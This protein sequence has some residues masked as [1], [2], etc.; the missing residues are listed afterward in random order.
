MSKAKIERADEIPL[1]LYWL[2]KMQVA[3]VIDRVLPA[4]HGNRQGLS[5]GQLAVLFVVYV[6]YQRSHRLSGMEEWVVAHQGVL[7]HCTGWSIEGQE[8]TDDRLGDLLSELGEE[9]SRAEE[10]QSELGR[11]LLQAYA[12]PT[13]RV[14]YDTTSFSVHHAPQAGGKA[15]DGLLRFGHSK[16][17]RP[18]LLQFKQ[19]LG[20]LD[21]AGVP[22]YTETLA[23]NRADDP[24]YVPAW[25]KL[26]QTIGHPAFLFIA[27]SKAA[28]L[29]SRAEIDHEQGLYLFPLP[30]T[31]KTPE[32]LRDWVL[33]PP[34]APAPIVLG[35]RQAA[36]GTVRQVGEGF[37]IELGLYA[38]LADGHPRHHWHERWLVTRSH[39]L[40]ERRQADLAH[41]LQQAE[42]ELARLNPK[43]KAT[44]SDLTTSAQNVL[45]RRR[46]VGLLSVTVT[47][48]H[49]AQ[50]RLLGRGRPGPN[51][52]TAVVQHTTT[53]LTVG[54]QATA[55]AE[56]HQL[57]GWRIHV[58]NA[59]ADHLSLTQA[60]D[61]YRDEYLVEQG[62][63]RFKHGSLPVLPLFLQLP[64]RIRGLLLLLFIALQ[65]LTLL[66]FVAQQALA[67]QNA[68]LAGLVPGNPKMQTAHPSAERLLARFAGLHW[69]GQ[70]S[71][72]SIV[73]DLTPLQTRILHLLGVPLSIY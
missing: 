2:E 25:R 35:D 65:A 1:L 50:V 36:A 53:T 42:A 40:A 63:H 55:I 46:V 11:H 41:R 56:A 39:A 4:P 24:L 38:T 29:L 72:G 21:P 71:L 6:I 31:G 33:H 58:T 20:T 49:T 45:A 7:A 62:M 64:Q 23:G 73:E 51:R 10:V 70:A 30:M 5:Y 3:V 54:R 22:L 28:A 52:T 43:G 9:E 57:A 47:E 34:V 44:L 68:Q 32:P 67:Q 19:G 61:Y 69:L 15:A 26:C 48:T 59:P 17:G 18:D 16:D 13:E 12:L 60:I 37:V 14:R 27:A 66:A 8:A